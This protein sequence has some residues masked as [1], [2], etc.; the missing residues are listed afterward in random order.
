[1]E[2][3]YYN[4][5][6]RIKT[7]RVRLSNPGHLANKHLLKLPFRGGQAEPAAGKPS[8]AAPAAKTKEK[9]RARQVAKDATHAVRTQIRIHHAR[10]RQRYWQIDAQIDFQGIFR[11]GSFLRNR[12]Q[13]I[14]SALRV[15]QS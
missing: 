5:N 3:S 7:E 6:F 10:S 11:K 13:A 14:A 12:I 4:K 8:T 15:M 9:H 1:M 2:V